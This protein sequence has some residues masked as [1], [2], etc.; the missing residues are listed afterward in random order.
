MRDPSLPPYDRTGYIWGLHNYVWSWRKRPV[1]RWPQYAA[2]M[3]A[4]KTPFFQRGGSGTWG[5]GPER[6]EAAKRA[7]R[8]RMLTPTRQRF[9]SAENV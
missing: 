4:G 5:T 9:E 2:L 3:R 1:P 8:T 6:R 7:A